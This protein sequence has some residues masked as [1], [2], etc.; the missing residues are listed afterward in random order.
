MI[1]TYNLFAVQM[2]HCILPLDID[3]HKKITS[4]VEN[5]YKE[6]NTVSC[7]K[8]FQF[9][10]DF[11]G[12][13]ELD[14]FLNQYL[15]NTFSYEIN[16]SWLNVLGNNSYNK[17]HS[18]PGNVVDLSAVYYLSNNNNN[19]TFVKEGNFFEL[20]PKIFDLLIFP[21]NLVH[22]VLPEERLE[23]RICYAFNMS[24]I[25]KKEK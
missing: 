17:P 22:Y 4:F 9:H 12:K 1:H 13:K 10:G 7:T 3:I 24:K 14:F 20:K 23:K 21:Y 16:Y 5:E 25:I 6:E 19:I 18:H 15:I 8:G 2:S 11:N